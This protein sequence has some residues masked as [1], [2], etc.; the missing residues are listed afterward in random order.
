MIGA[1]NVKM[2]GGSHI[3]LALLLCV[4]AYVMGA[5]RHA[6]PKI[7]S[8]IMS[9]HSAPVSLLS[10]DSDRYF[11]L[12][13][14]SL[15]YI[16]GNSNFELRFALGP[17]SDSKALKALGKARRLA[18]G[19]EN[20]QLDG[21][22]AINTNFQASII[23]L[24]KQDKP[25]GPPAHPLMYSRFE[26]GDEIALRVPL[27]YSDEITHLA[28]VLQEIGGP[29]GRWVV[30]C[31]VMT[32]DRLRNAGGDVATQVFD[33]TR[34]D[35]QVVAAPDLV[36]Y[37]PEPMDGR[38]RTPRDLS[39]SLEH[40]ITGLPSCA[41]IVEV[42]GPNASSAQGRWD[43]VANR[44]T[45]QWS[46][47]DMIVPPVMPI[48]T[49]PDSP[50]CWAFDA[51]GIYPGQQQRVRIDGIAMRHVS[52]PDSVTF[53]NANVDF[54]ASTST[55]NVTWAAQQ[56]QTSLRG[57]V[58]VAIDNRDPA[59]HRTPPPP[60]GV[61]HIRMFFA[62]KPR[63]DLGEA[64][65]WIRSPSEVDI[66]GIVLR[67]AQIH[68]GTS[69]TADWG[70]VKL[71]GATG[72]KDSILKALKPLIADGYE[73]VRYDVAAVDTLPQTAQTSGSPLL[74]RRG[75]WKSMTLKF[76]DMKLVERHKLT[77]VVPVSDHLADWPKNGMIGRY[78]QITLRH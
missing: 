63:T 47:N 41:A 43:F 37:A 24:D 42:T 38:L 8:T 76:D 18:V 23:C 31:P 54:D 45:R 75:I 71:P 51:G 28:V 56:T 36:P 6:H 11:R 57:R 77:F 74:G 9:A 70:D 53:Q 61:V 62:L 12:D 13:R 26:N 27:F 64:A 55:Y 46:L 29:S 60:A 19:S 14:R 67:A 20:D 59:S 34:F 48:A 17:Q 21:M 72:D 25:I 16:P 50:T 65:L 69:Q 73:V 66:D 58:M 15:I 5:Y 68:F 49:G 4:G 33:G 35:A 10:S 39:Q 2:K 3:A 44:V 30:A 52:S 40:F 1:P 78:R 32:A 22:G 7:T